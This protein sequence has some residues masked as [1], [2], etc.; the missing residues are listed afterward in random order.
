MEEIVMEN[1]THFNIKAICERLDS[2]EDLLKLSLISNILDGLDLIGEKDKEE[3]YLQMNLLSDEIAAYLNDLKIYEGRHYEY[4][5]KT[6][7]ELKVEGFISIQNMK[8]ICEWIVDET[9]KVIP[10]FYFKKLNGMK[11]KRMLEEKISFMVA[12][13]E[14]HIVS[15]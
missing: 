14:V 11:R 13:R 3:A 1:S 12:D 6:F 4:F 9:K 8:D 5:N 7:I 10:V 15:M 2:I